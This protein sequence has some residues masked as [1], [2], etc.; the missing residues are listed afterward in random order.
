[1]SVGQTIEQAG[2]NVA[3]GSQSLDDDVHKSRA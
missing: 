2:E 3:L 1:L